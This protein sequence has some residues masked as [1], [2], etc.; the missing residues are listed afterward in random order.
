MPWVFIYSDLGP[1]ALTATLSGAPFVSLPA[2]L[3]KYRIA[4]KG[5][6]RKWGGA[7]ATLEKK[8]KAWVYGSIHLLPPDDIKKLDKHYSY[9]EKITVPIFIDATQDK[10]KAHTYIIKDA[11]YGEPSDEYI[12]ALLKHLKFFWGQQ[13]A[14]KPKLETFGIV[15]GAGVPPTVKTKKSKLAPVA[16]PEEPIKKARKPRRRTAKS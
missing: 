8:S 10:V 6:S 1:Q 16:E 7:V 11:P 5:K 4:F 3:P 2:S 15:T 9:F 13:G 12:K 14:G